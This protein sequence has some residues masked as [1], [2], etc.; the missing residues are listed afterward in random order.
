MKI[1]ILYATK[2]GVSRT[3]A[4]MLR[5]QLEPTHEITLCPIHEKQPPDPRKTA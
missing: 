1:L 4:K 5:E 3:C 2:G